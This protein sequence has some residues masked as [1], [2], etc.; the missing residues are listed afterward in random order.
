MNFLQ[1]IE[2]YIRVREERMKQHNNEQSVRTL[3]ICMSPTLNWDWQFQEV[4]IKMEESIGKLSNYLMT[5][6]L[7]H[8]Y[9]NSYLMSKVYIG[10]GIKTSMRN[11]ISKKTRIGK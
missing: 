11:I 3:G 7:T 10:C 2:K 5:V 4:K 9:V 6:Q 8:S 1:L